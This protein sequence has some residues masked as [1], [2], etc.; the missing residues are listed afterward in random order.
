MVMANHE[1]I[2]ITA[3]YSLNNIQDPSAD[4][5]MAILIIIIITL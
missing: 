2:I 1:T 3:K 4:M 5:V